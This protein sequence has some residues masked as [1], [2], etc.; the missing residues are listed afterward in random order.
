MKK[1]LLQILLLA[2]TM[3]TSIGQKNSY[4]VSAGIGRGF[5]IQE[6]LMGGAGH[7][8]NNGIL[9]GFQYTRKLN[10]KF[11]LMTGINW[12]YYRLSVTP[13]FY[14]GVERSTKYYNFNLIYLPA[15]IK[16][17]LSKHFFLDGGLIGDIDLT[18]DK[19]ISNQTG[20]G[21]GLGVGAEVM[22]T[23][24]F[25]IQLDPYLNFHGLN[26]IHVEDYPERVFDPG[27][28]LTFVMRK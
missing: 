5:I 16:M 18:K 24:Q 6:P 26:M 11:H 20:I 2:G 3:N 19:P 15:F 12:C 17:N 27:I 28:K 1:L 23:H 9:L 22:V 14:P 10:D 7:D 21:A 13:N 4:G 8:L 25:T